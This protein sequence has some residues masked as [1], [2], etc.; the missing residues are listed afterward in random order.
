VAGSFIV[1]LLAVVLA[2]VMAFFNNDQTLRGV[3][4]LIT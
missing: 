4:I 3:A 2:Q 1:G